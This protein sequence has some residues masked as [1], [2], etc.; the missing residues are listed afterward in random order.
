MDENDKLTPPAGPKVHEPRRE[1]VKA[2]SKNWIIGMIVLAL[3]SILGQLGNSAGIQ[4]LNIK[5]IASPSDLINAITQLTWQ[6]GLFVLFAV[7]GVGAV[8]FL[9]ISSNIAVGKLVHLHR[10]TVIDDHQLNEQIRKDIKKMK[11]VPLFVW[12]GLV[13]LIVVPVAGGIN[14]IQGVVIQNVHDKFGGLIL[15][16]VVTAITIAIGG[17]VTGYLM[18]RLKKWYDGIYDRIEP[19]I[20]KGRVF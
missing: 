16:Y 11:I 13:A 4:E 19:Y 14:S 2:F 3:F 8:T 17:A 9:L 5:T 12:M 20:Q 7:S 6:Q 15:S 1:R 10:D 18:I